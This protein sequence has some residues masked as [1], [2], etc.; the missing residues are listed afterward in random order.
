[1]NGVS[2]S[3]GFEGF[4]NVAGFR[5]AADEKLRAHDLDHTFVDTEYSLL[6]SYLDGVRWSVEV[7]LHVSGIVKEAD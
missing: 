4:E 5:I 2:K 3:W 7:H 1:M 6:Q